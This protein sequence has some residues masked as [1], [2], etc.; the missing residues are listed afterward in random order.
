MTQYNVKETLSWTNK[1]MI[2]TAG[3]LAC[4]YGAVR[5]TFFFI[6]LPYMPAI[7]FICHYVFGQHL[8]TCETG[9]STLLGIYLLC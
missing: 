4:T 7:G 9:T 2:L 3:L 5:G 6:Y 1:L 8:C